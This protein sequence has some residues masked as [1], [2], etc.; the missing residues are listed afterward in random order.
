MDIPCVPGCVQANIEKA[1]QIGVSEAARNLL[2]YWAHM[3]PDPVGLTLP[4]RDKGRKIAKSRI[5]PLFRRT[6]VLRR[7][8]GNVRDALIETI[9]LDNGFQLDLMWSGSASS[10][11]SNPFR[12]VINDEVDKFEQW[13]GDEPD[14]IGRTWKRMRT[15]GDRRLQ[16][17]ISTPT[18]TTGQI[19]VLFEASSIKL[20]FFVPCPHCGEFQRLLWP[21]LKW[22]KADAAGGKNSLADKVVAAGDAWYECP[23]C[24]QRIVDE[25]KAAM[26][27]SGRWST[28]EGYVVDA[29]GEIHADAE[30][31]ERW[32]NGTRIGMQI[33]ALYCLWEHWAEIAA[34]FLRAEGSLTKSYNFRTETL[35]EPFEFQVRRAKTGL[36]ADKCRRATLPAGVVPS[37]GWVLLAT[38]DTQQDHFYAVVRAWGSGLRSQRVWHGKLMRF[39]DLDRLLFATT[40]PVEGGQFDP[41]PIAMALID[42]GGTED[43]LLGVSRTMQVYEWVVPRQTVIRAIK[44]AS[45]PGTGLYWAMKNPIGRSTAADSKRK[46][47]EDLRGWLVDTQRCNDLLADWMVRGIPAPAGRSKGDAGEEGPEVWLLNRNDDDE[48]NHHMAAMH[49]TADRRGAGVIE[50]WK[51][52]HAGGRHDYHDCE[53][54]QIAA[55]YMASVHLLPPEDVLGRMRQE[56]A[57]QL[58]EQQARQQ[59]NQK[60]RSNA[61]TPTEL[62]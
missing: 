14:P 52:V 13:A 17:N 9:N 11:A 47:P 45:R 35:G 36:F 16:F 48:Y 60:R 23:H 24:N 27:R 44:G 40:W 30:K 41:Q 32:P 15:Y 34:E 37:W 29:W 43:R 53:A 62:K 46:A 56:Q 8:L 26:I 20:H 57:E 7:L 55:A 59:E 38:I 33:P 4:D 18:K 39:E 51:P 25:Q 50:A 6:G 22:S 5:L 61:W 31:V 10:T 19:H 12:R 28:D 2:G 21:Q 42:S 58:R 3:E 49:K 54:Y 1:A